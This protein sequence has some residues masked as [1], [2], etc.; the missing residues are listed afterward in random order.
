MICGCDAGGSASRRRT[1]PRPGPR[2]GC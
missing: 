2:R 1:H